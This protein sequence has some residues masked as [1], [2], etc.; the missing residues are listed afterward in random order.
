MA[1]GSTVQIGWGSSP[2]STTQKGRVGVSSPWIHQ[3]SDRRRF[4]LLSGMARYLAT[5]DPDSLRVRLVQCRWGVTGGAYLRSS[6]WGGRAQCFSRHT[7]SRWSCSVHFWYG[8]T[9]LYQGAA[10]PS[11]WGK[12]EDACTNGLS[13]APVP[14]LQ[15]GAVAA[16]PSSVWG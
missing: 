15:L 9:D 8:D 1:P 3:Q 12:G 16:A 14:A 5:P 10:T 13:G 7:D 6:G 11:W 2:R 4:N